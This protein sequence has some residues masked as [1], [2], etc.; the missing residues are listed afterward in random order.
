VAAT[1]PQDG[2][3]IHNVVIHL[4]N[5]QPLVADLFEM[6]A[7]SDRTLRCTNLRD[8]SGKRPIFADDMASIFFFAL[9]HIRFIE[10]L[11][12]STG[13]TGDRPLAVSTAV[14]PGHGPDGPNPDAELDL[15]IDEDFLRRIREV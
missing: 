5:E 9:E 11:P 4:N 13:D 10:I 12:T 14:R 1:G 6:P 3:V 8:L 15:E 2:R 7:T